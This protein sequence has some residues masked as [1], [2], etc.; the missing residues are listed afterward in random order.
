MFPLKIFTPFYA[1]QEEFVWI[2]LETEIII[3]KTEQQRLY[4]S[5]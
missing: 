5:V 2:L 3:K 4:L 1:R